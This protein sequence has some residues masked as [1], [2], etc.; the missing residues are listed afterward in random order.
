[1]SILKAK[2]GQETTGVVE[3]KRLTGDERSEIG[4]SDRMK[5]AGNSPQRYKG[6]R[7]VNATAAVGFHDNEPAA[8]S[9]H[10]L[11]FLKPPPL[12]WPMLQRGDTVDALECIV[13]E[14]E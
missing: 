5:H 1:L 10:A 11:A 9:Q 12:V 4:E 14:G 2:Y 6:A 13:R 3:V 7:I 8:R